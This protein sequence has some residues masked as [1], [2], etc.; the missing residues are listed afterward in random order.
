[1]Q[2]ISE[3]GTSPLYIPNEDRFAPSA[4]LSARLVSTLEKE[5]VH[6]RTATCWTT[7]A[8]F[9]E[10]PAKARRFREEGASVVDMEASALFA[11]A[12][13]RGIELASVFVVSDELFDGKWKPG[14]P[15][16]G[17]RLSRRRCVKAL[18]KLRPD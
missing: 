5:G 10:T 16:P 9:R 15:L 8:F 6:P 2:A 7:D 1:M 18:Q 13:C 17:F 4:R 12:A 3:E 11:V 14:F